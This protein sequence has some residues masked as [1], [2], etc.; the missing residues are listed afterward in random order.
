MEP[1]LV[2]ADEPTSMLDPSSCA[3]VL[4]MLKTLQNLRGFA[5]LIITHDLEGAA[6]IS[7]RIYLLKNEKLTRVRPSDYVT[8]NFSDLLK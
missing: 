2:I 7:D 1:K 8:A 4:R 3:N 6:K 5:M